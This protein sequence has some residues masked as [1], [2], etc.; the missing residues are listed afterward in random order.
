MTAPT[1]R[2]VRDDVLQV[3]WLETRTTGEL[4]NTPTS[5]E[6]PKRLS[7]KPFPLR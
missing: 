4:A 6:Y 7:E 5:S 3:R 1:N 2:L